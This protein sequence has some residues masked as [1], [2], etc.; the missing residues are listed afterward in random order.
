MHHLIV[1][2]AKAGRKVLGCFMAI[3]IRETAL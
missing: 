1:L 2:V 3:Y